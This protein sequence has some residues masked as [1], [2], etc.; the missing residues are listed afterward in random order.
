M[1]RSVVIKRLGD[2]AFRRLDNLRY[3]TRRLFTVSGRRQRRERLLLVKRPSS[4][5]DG[6][7]QHVV[8]R[9]REQR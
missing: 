3:V 9:L 6:R 7:L 1:N 4:F 5:L 8:D 2:E